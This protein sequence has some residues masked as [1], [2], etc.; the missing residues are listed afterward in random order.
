MREEAERFRRLR[1]KQKD[2]AEQQRAAAAV[3]AQELHDELMQK[4]RE[5]RAE[6]AERN[7]NL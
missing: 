2:R 3:A 7:S 6:E 4:Q 1:Q 5:I